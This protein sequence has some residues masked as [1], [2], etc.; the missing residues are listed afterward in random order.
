MSTT[1]PRTETTAPSLALLSRSA[2]PSSSLQAFDY[3]HLALRI[4]G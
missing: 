3:L 2:S 4:L 1:L